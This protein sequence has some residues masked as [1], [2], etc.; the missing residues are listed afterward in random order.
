MMGGV[1]HRVHHLVLA[2]GLVV[3]SALML[4]GYS[5]DSPTEDELT[6]M[7]RGIAYWRGSDTRLS[8]AHPPLGNAWTALPVAWDA[9]N[10]EIDELSG[11]KTATASTT[12]KSYVDKDYAH[13][14]EQLMRS[15]L[16]AMAIGLMLVAYLYYFCLSVFGLRTALVLLVL[17]VFNPIIIAQCR[18]V[19]TDPAAMLGF[20][21]ALGELIRYLRGGRYGIFR[22]TLGISLALLTKYS[23]VALAPLALLVTLVCCAAGQGIFAGQPPRQRWLRLARDSAIMIAGIVLCINLAYK[24]NGSGMTVGAILD[25]TEPS[26]WVSKRYPNLLERFTPLPRLP[27]ALPVPIPYTFMFGLAGIRGHAENGFTSYFWGKQLKK[28]PA[29]Y[30]PVLLAIKNPPGMLALLAAAGVLLVRRRRL[31]LASWVFAA[32][33]AT[34]LFMASK[35]N[36][37]MGVRHALPVVPPLSMLAARAFELLWTALPSLAPRWGLGATLASVAFSGITAGA[38]YLGYFNLFAG[39]RKSGHEISIYGEDWGQDRQRLADLVKSR[40]LEPF[41]YDPQTE[42]RAMEMEYLGL[43]FRPLLCNTKVTQ[44]WVAIHAL[45]YRTRNLKTCWRFLKGREPDLQVNN[46][47]YLWKFESPAATKANADEANVEAL[48]DEN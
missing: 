39:G 41:Y 42:M 43:R 8:Y 24:G 35:S 10:P 1:K 15:R 21:V 26:Y 44:G 20:S 12:T 37:A 40:K 11:W 47:I 34:F 6:H 31:S 2:L 16:A 32:G 28:A 38:D 23:G 25:R 5:T 18:Y 45:T 3:M 17:L 22:A 27:R 30:F 46:H 4:R 29:S 33:V 9:K 14:R 48:P 13:A 7:V 36:L 19:T